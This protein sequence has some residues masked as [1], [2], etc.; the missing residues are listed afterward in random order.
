MKT[1][2]NAQW[3]CRNLIVD[4]IPCIEN[5]KNEGLHYFN[6]LEKFKKTHFSICS[7]F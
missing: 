4:E 3:T 7:R 5:I 2:E 6:K 1:S